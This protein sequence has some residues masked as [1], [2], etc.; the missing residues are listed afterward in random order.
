MTNSTERKKKLN[1]KGKVNHY[2]Q[3]LRLGSINQI[4]PLVTY[5]CPDT[6]PSKGK[7]NRRLDVDPEFQ[8][9]TQTAYYN[10]HNFDS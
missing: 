5:F 6:E 4:Q 3:D 7:E 8:I 1:T 2:L 9:K 10:C